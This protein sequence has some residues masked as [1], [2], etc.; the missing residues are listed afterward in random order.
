MLQKLEFLLDHVAPP[1][2]IA[3]FFWIWVILLYIPR[4][5]NVQEGKLFLYFT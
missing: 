1:N 2:V 5:V 4:Y 3:I